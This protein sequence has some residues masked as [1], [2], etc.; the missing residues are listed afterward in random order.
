MYTETNNRIYANQG[1]GHSKHTFK[2]TPKVACACVTP[3]WSLT[4]SN[5][6]AK[7]MGQLVP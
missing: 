3:S 4:F 6:M 7:V 1:E 2:M 5:T